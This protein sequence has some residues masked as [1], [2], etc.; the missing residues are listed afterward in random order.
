MD[1]AKIHETCYVSV[2]S[3]KR[4]TTKNKNENKNKNE[5]EYENENE[6]EN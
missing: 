4:G 2:N 1:I 5:Y 6:N 3:S